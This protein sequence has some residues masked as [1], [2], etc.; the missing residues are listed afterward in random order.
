[1]AQRNLGAMYLY[2]KGVP[3]DW[4]YAYAWY[5]VAQANGDEKAKKWRDELG[6]TPELLVLRGQAQSL[7]TEIQ[8]R[9]EANRKD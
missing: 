6:L 5:N 3:K 9:I 2:G 7:S 1:M 4:V 8:K